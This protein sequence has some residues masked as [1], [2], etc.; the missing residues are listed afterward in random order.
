MSRGKIMMKRSVRALA[1]LASAI[2][3]AS[4]AMITAQPAGALEPGIR[5]PILRVVCSEPHHG[6]YFTAVRYKQRGL[7]AADGKV[8]VTLSRQ[9]SDRA[10]AVLHTHTVADGSFHLNRRLYSKDNGPWVRGATYT[11]TTAIYG[12][13]WA[14]AR[15]GNVT[16]TGS[17]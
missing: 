17:C 1:A 11:W 16:L 2:A 4:G 7:W 8:V 10:R 12:D 15:R 3:V 14:V 5:K 9:D 13:T 6:P